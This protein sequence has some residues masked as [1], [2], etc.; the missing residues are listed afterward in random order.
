MGNTITTTRPTTTRPYVPPPVVDNIDP[1]LIINEQNSMIN[2][3]KGKLEEMTKSL[4]IETFENINP[5]ILNSQS[6]PKISDYAYIYNTNI[7]L[8]DDPNNDIKNKFNTYIH[9][10]NKKIQSL[11][12]DLD[13][14]QKNIKTTD[15]TKD[16]KAFKSMDNS[17][18]LNVETYTTKNTNN[19]NNYPNYLIY[20]NNGCLQYE[21]STKDINNTINPAKW[22]F[23][24]CNA[25]DP[26]QQF[27][28]TQ[29]NDLPTYNK[30]ITDPNNK[31]YILNNNNNVTFGFNVVNPITAQ[32]DQCLQL[33]NDGISVMSCNLQ[34]DQRFK[35][36][37]SN[38]LN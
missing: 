32:T 36:L 11:R 9:L 8:L 2:L 15:V 16:I 27:I 3:L 28:S 22:S 10:Q 12:K 38:V 21:K 1:S 14:L 30:Y 24:S 19:N 26:R 23:Q 29:I 33:N 4:T 6:Y 13:I 31:N 34:S 37:Y 25:T 7:A 20:G 35:P 18:I 5:I 17:Q